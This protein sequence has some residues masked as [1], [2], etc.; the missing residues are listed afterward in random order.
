MKKA[1]VAVGALL[2]L[3]IGGEVAA[4]AVVDR[5]V[6]DALRVNASARTASARVGGPVLLGL[7]AGRF[8]SVHVDVEGATRNGLVVERV[9]ADLSDVR[10]TRAVLVGRKGDVSAGGGT[11]QVTLGE[12][13]VNASLARTGLRVSFDDAITGTFSVPRL[14]E[15]SVRVSLQ[16]RG[17]NL[18]LVPEGV[19]GSGLRVPLPRA[20]PGLPLAF[21]PASTTLLDSSASGGSLRVDLRFGPFT[22][23]EAR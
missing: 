11:A 23:P 8:A 14:G 3:A 18:V 10:F 7:V 12:D 6:S 9:V 4:R 1:L 16:S 5:T 2:V 19:S 13:A 20:M 15:V 21:L 22:V 17:G